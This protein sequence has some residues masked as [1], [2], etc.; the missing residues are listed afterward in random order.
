MDSLH[1][2]G[3]YMSATLSMGGALLVAFLP[4]REL[5]GLA[6]VAVG[7]G[8]A[9]IALSLSAGYA[10]IAILVS[11]VAIT[12][13][14]AGPQYRVLAPAIS[15]TWRQLGALGAAGLFA[16]LAYAAFRGDFVHATFYG[17]TFGAASVGRLLF[18]HDAMSTEAVGA[19]IV[20]ALVGATAVWRARDRGR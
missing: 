1:A 13:L 2:I 10:A 4:G 19:L 6:L 8:L 16:L 14:L 7:V 11:Y 5:R 9:G 15:G 3:F 12:A 18:A 17:G 20:V